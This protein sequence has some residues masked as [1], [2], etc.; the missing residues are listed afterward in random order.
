MHR[1]RG[2]ASQ[3]FLRN[4]FRPIFFRDGFNLLIQL[5]W[6]RND[7]SGVAAQRWGSLGNPVG[8]A[9]AG[10]SPRETPCREWQTRV[11][12]LIMTGIS[13]SSEIW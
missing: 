5:Q 4:D 2:L 11:V 12:G 6:R 3:I 7:T 1:E 13:N 9:G 10:I 8:R